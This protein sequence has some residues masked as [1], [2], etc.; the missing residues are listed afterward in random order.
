VAPHRSTILGYFRDVDHQGMALAVGVA[1]AAAVAAVR[2]LTS[3]EARA[4]RRLSRAPEKPLGALVDGDV[5]RMRCMALRAARRCEAPFSLRRCIG[6]RVTVEEYVTDDGHGGGGDWRNIL[7]REECAVFD[8]GADGIEARVEGPF[9]L[10]VEIDTR[11]ADDAQMLPRDAH[12]YETLGVALTTAFGR[13]R[14]LRYKEAAL[15]IGDP[16]WVL[17]RVSVVVDPR[18]R[19]ESI[20][21]QPI[22]RVIRGTE[23]EPVVLADE[24]VPGVLDRFG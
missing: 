15:E 18:G 21:G 17:G 9:A 23:R 16:I 19:R 14:R 7:E 22:M 4:R 6:F 24:D 12:V 8:I 3:A 11:S 5:A 13:A 1:A 2:H 20:R 10:A